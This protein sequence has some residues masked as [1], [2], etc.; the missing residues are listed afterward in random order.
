MKKQARRAARISLGAVALVF[1]APVALIFTDE[2]LPMAR[3]PVELNSEQQ[4]RIR[5]SSYIHFRNP[6]K[7]E[8]EKQLLV[9]T[10]LVEGER[11]R[12]KDDFKIDGRPIN[13]VYFL[14]ALIDVES[15]FTR[16]AVSRSDARGYMQMK[17]DTAAWVDERLTPTGAV[18]KYEQAKA[19][20]RI[21][22]RSVPAALDPKMRDELFSAETNVSRGVTYLNFLI[23]EFGDVRK[24]CLAYNAGPGSAA[25]GVWDES[26]WQKTLVAYRA[27]ENGRFLAT[28]L[29]T[30]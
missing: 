28:D 1:A 21:V 24:V 10:L 3:P 5:I 22:R 14:A 9:N 23:D 29:K 16:N 7:S 8:A 27:I 13:P 26:Y 11:L 19:A 12:L 6:G 25:R 30:L 15:S 20:G 4:T 2:T 17:P 18:L